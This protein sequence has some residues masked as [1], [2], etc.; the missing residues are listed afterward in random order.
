MQRHF[1]DT[2]ETSLD[3]LYRMNEFPFIITILWSCLHISVCPFLK[4]KRYIQEI[5]CWG[6]F[7]LNHEERLDFV[8][9]TIVRKTI[10]PPKEPILYSC[11]EC[12]Q[13][14]ESK[15][16]FETWERENLIQI[17]L[18]YCFTIA[19]SGLFFLS[20]T[21]PTTYILPPFRTICQS[22]ESVSSR[23]PPRLISTQKISG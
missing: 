3:C 11:G 15:A 13:H 19:V 16:I 22:S 18:C 6:N 8:T 12:K 10:Y 1:W 5:M 23:F 21:P 9:M 17:F 2:L 14:R 20:T 4:K 7:K